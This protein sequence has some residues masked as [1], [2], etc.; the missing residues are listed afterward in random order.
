MLTEEAAKNAVMAVAA[1]DNAETEVRTILRSDR[2]VFDRE[3]CLAEI[4]ALRDASFNATFDYDRL[5]LMTKYR[6]VE[7]C[8]RRFPHLTFSRQLSGIHAYRDGIRL[9]RLNYWIKKESDGVSVMF[10]QSMNADCDCLTWEAL[11]LTLS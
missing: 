6:F 5:L 9:F 8:E 2:Y 1:A 10:Y 11:E 4:K 3:A 7:E